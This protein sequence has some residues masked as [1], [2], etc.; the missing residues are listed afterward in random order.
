MISM[1]ISIETLPISPDIYALENSNAM[2][3]YTDGTPD[4]Q[5]QKIQDVTAIEL[6]IDGQSINIPLENVDH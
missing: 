3:T 6:R 2:Y 4:Q 1:N 5:N